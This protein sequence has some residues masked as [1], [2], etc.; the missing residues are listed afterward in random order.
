MLGARVD[1]VIMEEFLREKFPK[2]MAHFDDIMYMPSM[3]TMQW[4]T[5]LFSYNFNFE[6]VQRLWDVYFLKGDRMLFRISLAIYH[7]LEK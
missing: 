6:V 4:F 2:L 3:N 5:C 7:L 1:Q